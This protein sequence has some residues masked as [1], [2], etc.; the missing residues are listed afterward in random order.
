MTNAAPSP[1]APANIR[2]NTDISRTLQRM[3]NH[4]EFEGATIQRMNMT[5]SDRLLT[6]T[7]VAELLNRAPHTVRRWRC[8]NEGPAYLRLPGGHV[9]YRLQDLEAYA[10]LR[11]I[12]L[13]H[14]P[15]GEDQE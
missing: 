6:T 10:Q 15:Q 2:K 12:E 7:Q 11:G 4:S 5:A 1:P 14:S 13:R 9:R 3:C 8:W